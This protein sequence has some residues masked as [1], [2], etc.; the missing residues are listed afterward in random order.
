MDVTKGK[1][2]K[3]T[4]LFMNPDGYVGVLQDFIKRM[5]ALCLGRLGW[6]RITLKWCLALLCLASWLK[7]EASSDNLKYGFLMVDVKRTWSV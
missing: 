2:L 6:G 4:S 1:H 3:N 7:F 5:N